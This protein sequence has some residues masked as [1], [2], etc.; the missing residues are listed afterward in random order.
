[1]ELK[2]SNMAD[3][4]SDHRLF[5][6]FVGYTHLINCINSTFRSGVE[7]TILAFILEILEER[8]K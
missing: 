7:G 5:A 2:T 3:T 6:V 8:G 4:D 1:M